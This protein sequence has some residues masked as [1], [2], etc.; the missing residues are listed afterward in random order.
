MTTESNIKIFCELLQEC[1]D[2]TRPDSNTTISY[3]IGKKYCMVL[4][5]TPICPI[6]S[7]YIKV[8]M[9]T[10]DIYAPSGKLII[11]NINIDCGAHVISPWTVHNKNLPKYHKNGVIH[12][13]YYT[14][15]IAA[16]LSPVY[17]HYSQ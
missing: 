8:D 10:G 15:V 16:G 6:D 5:R 7:T 17:Q 14:E 12:S 1:V 13:K 11:G 9:E 4:E 2:R 3:N